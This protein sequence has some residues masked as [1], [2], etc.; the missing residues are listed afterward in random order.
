MSASPVA[1]AST[2]PS[3]STEAIRQLELAINDAI[4]A[5][6]QQARAA[7]RSDLPRLLASHR[8]Q[9]VAYEGQRQAGIG[10]TKTELVQQCLAAGLR[11]SEFV[12]LLIEPEAD[13]QVTVPVD[14]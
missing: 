10:D 9:W 13:Q 8:G 2:L 3:L 14:I 4:P 7:W 12:V 6:V 1:S 5:F 11:R